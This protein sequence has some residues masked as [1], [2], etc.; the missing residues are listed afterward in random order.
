MAHCAY[1]DHYGVRADF[2]SVRKVVR[3]FLI[4]SVLP[5]FSS[6][7]FT[8][9]D[10]IITPSAPADAISFACSGVLIPKPTHTGV[11]VRL[12]SLL[13]RGFTM[14]ESFALSPVTPRV[15]T[16][17]MKPVVFWAIFFARSSSVFGVTMNTVSRFAAFASGAISASSSMLRSA[18]RTEEPPAA[19][20]S[21]KNFCG[22]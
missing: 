10:P 6:I 9:R 15:D 12:F 7:I 14:S 22:P 16:V 5:R 11:S 13:M 4:F 3:S 20:K 21:V 17:Y 18:T 2:T 8:M 1:G 19:L